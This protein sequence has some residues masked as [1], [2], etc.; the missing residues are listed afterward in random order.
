MYCKFLL[1][2]LGHFSVNNKPYIYYILNCLY[3]RK[4][5]W[6]GK[7]YEYRQNCININLT[8]LAVGQEQVIVY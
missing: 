4:T 1:N 8:F 3:F 5:V 7:I 2:V 6:V